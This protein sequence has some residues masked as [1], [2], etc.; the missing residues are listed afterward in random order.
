MRVVVLGSGV[1]GVTS[2]YYLGRGRPRGHGGRPPGRAGAGN[3]LRQCRRGVARLFLALGRP[4]HADQGDQV[5]VDAPRP[6][7][8]PAEARPG[9]VAWGLQ[10]AAQ[11][12]RGAL[13]ASTRRAWC[14]SPNTAATACA[15]C[16]ATSGIA[17]DERSQGTLQLFRT[18]KQLDGIGNDIEVLKQLRRAVRGARPRRLRRR[19]AGAGDGARE[20]RRRP[21]PARRRDRRLLQCSPTRWPQLPPARR[22]VPLRHDDPAA[23]RPSGGRIT[24]VATGD[25]LVTADAYVVALGS[26]SPRLL[27]AARRAGAGLSGQGLLDHRADHRCRRRARNRPSW[28]RPTRWRSPGSATASASAA[29]PRSS[30]YDLT[31]R[32]ARRAHAGACRSSD[33]Y[34]GG[35]DVARRR[36]LV[37][38][39]ADDAR[40]ARR[41]IG[42]TALSQ[43]LSQHRPRHAGLDHGLRLRPRAGRPRLRPRARRSTRPASAS[44]RYA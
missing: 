13:R 2:A 19:R 24:G 31:L 39:A 32:E 1:I 44:R 33:L 34:P 38:P 10:D 18:Q 16:A 5:A 26:Y 27:R 9:H 42:P 25:G 7:G 41:S 28:T 15:S 11:L 37:R 6:A 20:V 29:R 30:G 4:G 3:Q 23:S 12:H 21:A 14:R 22:R 17:Y 35:G 8:D 36:V 40:T 43:P